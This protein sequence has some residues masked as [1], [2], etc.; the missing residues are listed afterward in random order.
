[1]ARQTTLNVSLTPR[2]REYVRRKVKSG[3]YESASEVIRESL[4]SL[5]ERDRAAEAL[6]GGVRAKVRVARGQVAAGKIVDGETAMEELLA[7]L[8]ADA[9]APARKRKRATR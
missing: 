4:R 8:H 5:E 7:E 1:M 3:R 9:D 2:L 6:W